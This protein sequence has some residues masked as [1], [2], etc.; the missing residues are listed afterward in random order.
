MGRPLASLA[1]ALLGFALAATAGAREVPYLTGRVNDLAELLGPETED[2]IE[3]K[4]AAYEQQTGAQFAILTIDSLEGEVLE[5][6]SLRVAETWALGRAEQDDGLLLLIARDDRKMRLE[7]GYG[8]EERLTDLMSGRILNNILRPAFRRGDFEGGIERGVD[9]TLA[10]LGGA[11]SPPG[12]E[13]PASSGSGDL[14]GAPLLFRLVFFGFFLL[15]VGMFAV[16]ALFSS[17]C[18]SWFLWLFLMPFFGT[19]PMVL[20]PWAGFIALALWVIG[21]PLL[22]IWFG[23][24]ESGKRWLDAHPGWTTFASRGFSGGSSGGGG[25]FSGGG[26]SFGGG[27][28]SS[29]W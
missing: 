1:A 3:Q 26:G 22:K 18:G 15:V 8:L 23:R 19:F 13:A 25:G 16:S 10:V 28:A 17:G 4:L 24:T 9:A 21:F 12:E 20:H 2:R 14:A 29:S 27:G 11:E 6:Y 7:V 5:E